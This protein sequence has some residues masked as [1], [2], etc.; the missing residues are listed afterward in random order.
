MNS[1]ISNIKQS[2]D[3]TIS[4]LKKDKYKK[5]LEYLNDQYYNKNVSLL[6]D[7][8][9][10]YVKE[11][12]EEKYGEI[13]EV[14][15]EIKTDK[16]KLPYYMGSMNKLKTTK[17][18]ENWFS[19]YKGPFNISL[20][21]DGISGLLY[22]IDNKIYLVTRGDG[23]E[24]QNKTNLIKFININTSKLENGDYI[25]GEL[26]ISKKNFMKIATEFKNAR[27]ATSGII[28]S[29][30]VNEKLL[31]LVDFIG[32]AVMKPDMTISQ[33]MDFI[34][35]KDINCVY[36]INKKTVTI[37]ELS[38]MFD[39][40]RNNYKYE[41]DGLIITDNT[42]VYPLVEG[43]NPKYSFA[44]KKI[45]TDQQAETIVLDVIWTLQK[46]G[47]IT[48]KIKIEP[49]ELLGSTIEYAT[50]HNA[51]FIQENNI[52]VG[53]KIVIIK[54]GDVIPKIH[55]ILTSS[56][57]G[58]PA[59]PKMECKWD[60]T[61]THLI[62]TEIDD[63]QEQEMI[64]KQLAYTFDKLDVGNFSE[65]TVKKFVEDGYDSFWKILKA[66]KKDLE[67]IDGLST[68][69][70]NKI[71]DNIENA[72]HKIE[73]YDLMNA[74]ICFGRT[75]GSKKLKAILDVNPNLLDIYEE[76]GDKFTFE[77][78]MNIKGFEEKTTSKV[79]E[80]IPCFIKWMNKLIKIKPYMEE[81]LK[82]VVKKIIKAKE[83]RFKDKKI[84]FSGFRDKEMEEKLTQLG[85][86][87]V[88][89]VSKNTNILIVKDIDESSSKIDKAKEL[90][91]EI[92]NKEMT[93]KYINE[94]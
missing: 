34:K 49:V 75:I 52:G 9:Y 59:M 51:K 54:S 46:D 56:E 64:I 13:Q 29:K 11:K 18:M 35:D 25:R 84:C 20:K 93:E 57:L 61:K 82:P 63:D 8:L 30:T 16:M 43:E 92:L 85:A 31:K 86:S 83:N 22:K 91:I 39:E 77:L 5:L 72:L 1:L 89:G 41:I 36:N 94:I 7:Q 55:K 24:G 15:A 65:A 6:S 78:I 79:V 69:S 3:E 2:P 90:G 80:G 88:S 68:K 27:N 47:Y 74:S 33:Q 44:F 60:S 12:Y 58:E 42:K 14:G 40:Y 87:I 71:Y 50:A 32:Y 23:Y 81:K 26:I 70:I 48:P 73:L 28:N 37:D 76:K 67:S 66:N 10:D 4:N 17:E 53:S 38:E 62:A 19:K 45:M 21:L